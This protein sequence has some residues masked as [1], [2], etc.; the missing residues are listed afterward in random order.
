[1]TRPAVDDHCVRI[2]PRV[3]LEGTLSFRVLTFVLTIKQ[4]CIDNYYSM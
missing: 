2:A 1:M 4:V 3:T